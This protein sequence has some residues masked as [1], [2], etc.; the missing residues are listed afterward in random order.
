MED[1]KRQLVQKGPRHEPEVEE[2]RESYQSARANSRESVMLD[3][4]LADGSVESFPYHFLTRLKY[5]PGDTLV[6][7]FGKDEVNVEGRNLSVCAKPYQNIERG[8]FRKE[9]KARRG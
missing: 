1:C 7:R 6:L 8:L 3:V 4:Y 2:A 5:L 9:Q